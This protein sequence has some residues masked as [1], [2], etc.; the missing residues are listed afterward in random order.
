MVV[1]S[2]LGLGPCHECHD[3]STRSLPISD[4]C[5]AL[6]S[7]SFVAVLQYVETLDHDCWVSTSRPLT[8]LGTCG[9]GNVLL[10]A[11]AEVLR[12]GKDRLALHHKIAVL[13]AALF[14]ER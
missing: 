5:A 14:N 1:F 13:A 11:S 12:P 2:K 7:L 8:Y 6:L 10:V 4:S 3:R 9:V